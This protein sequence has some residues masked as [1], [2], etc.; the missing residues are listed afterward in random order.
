MI[1]H[2]GIGTEFNGKERREYAQSV[3]NPDS[4]MFVAFAAFLIDAA[5]I[6]APDT[7]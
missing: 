5:E 6:G 4:A 7:T 3:F 2:D 1:A